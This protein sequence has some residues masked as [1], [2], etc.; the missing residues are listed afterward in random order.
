MV[1]ELKHVIIKHGSMAK[2]T[3]HTHVIN[4]FVNDSLFYRY[5]TY[6]TGYIVLHIALIVMLHFISDT[7]IGLI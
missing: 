6:D 3:V 4:G 1:P 5:V 2:A 7:L